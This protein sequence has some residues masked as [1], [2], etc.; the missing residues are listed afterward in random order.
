M[1]LRSILRWA[2]ASFLLACAAVAAT[3]AWLWRESRVPPAATASTTFA[4]ERAVI[5]M[6]PA[7]DLWTKPGARDVA[8]EVG[9]YVLAGTFQTYAFATVQGDGQPQT[10][11]AIIDDRRA[12]QQSM[13]NEGDALGAFTVASIL[14]D[15][16]TLRRGDGEW[17]LRLSGRTVPGDARPAPV[18]VGKQEGEGDF[19]DMPSLGDSRFGKRIAENQ[20]VIQRDAVMAYANELAGDPRRYAALY[21]SFAPERSGE[22]MTGFRIQ[23]QGEKE[24][25]ESLGLGDQD[26][27]R[28]VNSMQMTNP[29]RAEYLIGEFMKARMSAVVLDIERDGQEEKR[30]Y[31]IR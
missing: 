6:I 15:Q 2:R 7:A 11:I 9:R 1:N 14:T 24:L 31:I 22:G 30:I 21:Q 20:W 28:K 8:E 3:A 23:P 13:V 5:P 18:A 12:G 4:M 19:A 27:I 10:R 17:V 26:V 16:V 29:R 25:F